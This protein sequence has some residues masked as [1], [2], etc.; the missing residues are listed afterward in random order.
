MLAPIVPSPINPTFMC[1][2]PAC[3]NSPS[4]V[5][6]GGACR[7]PL[8]ENV[9]G[10]LRRGHRRGPA[11]IKGE[12]R[13]DLADLLLRDAVVER[14]VQMANQLPLAAE[15]D[16]RRDDDEAAVALLQTRPLPHLAEQPLLAVIDQVGNDIADRFARR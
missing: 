1:I 12:M 6:R 10:D 13:D 15:R 8:R 5:S 7:L 16:Q 3:R 9:L 2:L 14:A 11:G 4:P